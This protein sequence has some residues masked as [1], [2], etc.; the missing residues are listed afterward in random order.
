M[1]TRRCCSERLLRL[2]CST[3]HSSGVASQRVLHSCSDMSGEQ[4]RLA[5]LLHHDFHSPQQ[6]PTQSKTD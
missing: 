2:K 3:Q 4:L 1:A 6:S 5:I